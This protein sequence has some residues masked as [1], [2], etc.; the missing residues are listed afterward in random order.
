MFNESLQWA[1][2]DHVG[3]THVVCCQENNGLLSLSFAF[4]MHFLSLTEDFSYIHAKQRSEISDPLAHKDMENPSFLD[5]VQ[6]IKH[7]SSHLA[8]T[9]HNY[10]PFNQNYSPKKSLSY[11]NYQS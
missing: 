1:R 4:H 7:H 9:N 6:P 8:T 10:S 3:P 2:K 5:H 11:I